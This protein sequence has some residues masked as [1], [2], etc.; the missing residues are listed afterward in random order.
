MAVAVIMP[1]QGQSV[2]SCIITEWK[3]KEGDAVY[4]GD[5]LFSYETDKASFEEEAKASGTLLKILAEEGDDVPVLQNVAVIGTPGEDISEFLVQTDAPVPASGPPAPDAPA[6]PAP[7]L[8]PAEPAA[9]EAASG[10]DRLR[11]SPRARVFA[12]ERGIDAANAVATGP[13]GRIVERDVRALLSAEPGMDE[14]RIEPA[15]SAAAALPADA[16]YTDVRLTN[17][18]KVIA[19]QMHASLQ[20]M[21]QLTSSASFDATEI[22]AYRAAVKQWREQMGLANI[23]LNDMVLYAVSRVLPDYRY[24]NAHFMDDSIREFRHVN[25]GMAV[26][27]PRGLLVPTIFRADTLSLDELARQAKTLAA[28]AQEGNISPDS[29]TGATFTVSNLGSFGVESFTPVVNP[30][31]TGIL[32]VN[33]IETRVRN[34][35]GTAVP[36]PAMALSLTFDHRAVDGAPAARFLKAL[37]QALS[38][39]MVLLAK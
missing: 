38:R 1:R 28:K 6:K 23:T 26:D 8:Q 19:R 3:K 13:G 12:Q 20:T 32:G 18:R 34:V 14:R 17:V 4:E 36:Y 33:T 22:L 9:Q 30:P 5:V 35:D 10:T 2:E 24:L 39:F 31:Q 21:A 25:L 16:E 27:T 37:C 29:L 7:A 11:I 15:E